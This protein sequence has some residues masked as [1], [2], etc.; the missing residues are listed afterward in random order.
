MSNTKFDF[1]FPKKF[2]NKV[3]IDCTYTLSLFH[4]E[5]ETL[6]ILSKGKCLER[7]FDQIPFYE[8]KANCDLTLELIHIL[9]KNLL[10][11]EMINNTTF[12]VREI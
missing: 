9:Y 4:Q 8:N 12:F 6:G 3:L 10:I 11:S 2:I 5:L 7:L 1:L